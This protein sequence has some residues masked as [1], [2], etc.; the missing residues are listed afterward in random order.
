VS[1][2]AVSPDGRIALVQAEMETKPYDAAT[3]APAQHEVEARFL[4]SD[5][6]ASAAR[7][8]SK[9]V[10]LLQRARVPAELALPLNGEG[11]VAAKEAFPTPDDWDVIY[12]KMSG[13]QR[14]LGDV[15]SACR[16]QMEF[17]SATEMVVETCNGSETQMEISVVT[18]DKRELWQS[19]LPSEMQELNLRTAAGSGRFVLESMRVVDGGAMGPFTTSGLRERVDVLD[20]KSGEM[21]A[22]VSATPAERAA[23]NFDL[24]PDGRQL[25]VLEGDGIGLF[26]LP[27]VADLPAAKIKP[28]DYIFV[29]AV[30]TAAGTAAKS[31]A[32][33]SG[34]ATEAVIEAPMNVDARRVAPTLLTPEEQAKRAQEGNKQGPIELPPVDVPKKQPTQE[35]PANPQN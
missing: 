22:S 31:A 7:G 11:Y 1:A 14:R 3:R 16:P 2:V 17:V 12:T 19:A 24:A 9:T 20:V 6:W 4:Q 33:S 35:Q 25:A 8:E 21:A 27:A 23:Q 34:K 15:V 18:L 32:E 26:N 13:E 30:E 10:K 5:D 28:K 29:A